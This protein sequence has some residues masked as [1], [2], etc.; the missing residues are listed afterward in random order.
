MKT[1]N[2]SQR[3]SQEPNIQYSQDT[4]QKWAHT[5][6]QAKNLSELTVEEE[7][8]IDNLALNKKKTQLQKCIVYTKL[9]FR[10][11]I[12]MHRNSYQF[13][14]KKHCSVK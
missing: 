12:N 7:K 1:N 13:P 11:H 14:N 2:N 10:S 4:T 6:C 3:D 9:P 8:P 5:K